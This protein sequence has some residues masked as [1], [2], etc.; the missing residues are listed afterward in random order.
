MVWWGNPELENAKK[1]LEQL[2]VI[3]DVTKGELELKKIEV[4]AAI[5]EKELA[6]V[7]C[8]KVIEKVNTEKDQYLQEMKELCDQKIRD[9]EEKSSKEIKI[10][11]QRYDILEKRLTNERDEGKRNVERLQRK[12]D[13]LQEQVVNAIN[14]NRDREAELRIE[15]DKKVER[16]KSILIEQFTQQIVNVQQMKNAHTD[17][18]VGLLT[19]HLSQRNQEVERLTADLKNLHTEFN[20]SKDSFVTYFKAKPKNDIE[21]PKHLKKIIEKAKKDLNLDTKNFYNIAFVGHTCTGKSSLINAI[22]EIDDRDATMAAPVGDMET[23]MVIQPYTFADP[24]LKHVKIYDVPGAG[25]ISHDAINY[26]R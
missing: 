7:D 2:K 14:D 1:E 11:R 6:E 16:E 18:V 8:Q 22:R 13:E 3:L 17:Q 15:C 21:I 9:F 10:E 19:Q 20:N 26:Y 24:Q 12:I 25:T 4:Q 23:T 5:A